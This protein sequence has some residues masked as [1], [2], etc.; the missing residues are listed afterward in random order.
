MR[1]GLAWVSSPGANYR[2]IEPLKAMARRGHEVVWPL[3][4]DGQADARLLAGCDLVHVYRRAGVETRRILMQLARHGTAITYDND[5]DFEEG[6]QY[7]PD[8]DDVFAGLKGQRQVASMLRTARLARVFTTTTEVLA[9]KYRR[10]GIER[11]EVI[12]NYPRLD[13]ATPVLDR[14]TGLVIGWKMP[15]EPLRPPRHNHDG[16]VIG[17]V[18]GG[19]HQ[20][21]ADRIEI[22]GA[23]ERLLAKHRDV[24]VEC[25][26]VDLKLGERYR[27]DDYVP[28]DDLP[29]R[30]GGF[31]VGIAPLA[32]IP[33][34]WARSDIKLKEYAASGVPWLASPLG[35]YLG[36]GEEQGGRLVADDGWFEAL[37][38]MVSK[39]RERRRLARNAEQWAKTQ[40]IDAVADRW[41]Q[42]FA[43]AAGVSPRGGSPGRPKVT[44]RHREAPPGLRARA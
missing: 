2:A 11:V 1:L 39:S 40:T 30:I 14:D 22:A 23:L 20:V 28:F 31:D 8:H 18:A 41:E 37:D 4:P 13:V 6:M 19:E 27:H 38:R 36:L 35:P 9:E 24:R 34:N 43:D 15:D 10:A 21:D 29:G 5:D 12:G 3:G 44:V 32:D 26:G 33:C 16:V 7:H 25:I 17:W 42:V